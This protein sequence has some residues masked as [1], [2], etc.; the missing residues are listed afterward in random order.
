MPTFLSIGA[1]AGIGLAT[2]ERFAKEGFTIVLAARSADKVQV[3]ADK[4]KVQGYAAEAVTADASD[5]S[6]I[7]ALVGNVV[8][9]HG[10]IDVLHYN[11]AAIRQA[12]ILDQPL[13]TFVPDLAANAGGAQAAIHAVGPAMLKAG[14]G[15]ILLTGGGFALHPSADYI[16]LSIGKAAI[17]TLAQGLFEPFK[18]K[19]VHVATVTVSTFVT[20]ES[21]HPAAIAEHFWTLHSQ[22]PG[23]WTWEAHY[24]APA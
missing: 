9:K 1:G 17:R 23:S 2:A 10:A 15:S 18:D 21:E 4:L 3:L 6:S 13:E 24:P 22:K 11:A 16:S 14:A 8:K 7:T 19:G 20:P 12:T 5:P